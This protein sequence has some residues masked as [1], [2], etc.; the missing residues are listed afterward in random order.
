M[1][2]TV[3]RKR[4]SAKQTLMRHAKNHDKE[5]QP[6]KMQPFHEGKKL[7]KIEVIHEGKQ[8][9]EI[10]PTGEE[11]ESDCKTNNCTQ[12]G[13]KNTAKVYIITTPNGKFECTICNDIFTLSRNATRYFQT[14][15]EKIKPFECAV[16]K[17][18][19]S[20]KQ[21]LMRHCVTAH[22]EVKQNEEIKPV[23]EGKVPIYEGKGP[24]YEANNHT[25]D[26]KKNTWKEFVATNPDGKWFECAVCK[27]YF[28]YKQVL[29]NRYLHVHNVVKQPNEIKPW[30][31]HKD[32]QKKIAKEEKIKE[33]YTEKY[34]SAIYVQEAVQVS[35]T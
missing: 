21:V 15:H 11:K 2:N 8:S 13:E 12:K 32:T 29:L 30:L 35:K 16:C 4:F 33:K 22:M 18:C 9:K 3:C 24:V 19:F 5:K 20:A 1:N 17:R 31:N 28:S 14:V 34:I 26:G 7:K 25:Q 23:Y 27:K 6:A 10:E